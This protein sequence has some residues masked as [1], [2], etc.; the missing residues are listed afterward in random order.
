MKRMRLGRDD[1]CVSCGMALK[2]G[3]T[4]GWESMT[5]T[6]TCL[7]CLD[8]T[9]AYAL[10]AES[11]QVPPRLDPIDRGVAG[12][13]VSREAERR[14]NRHRRSQEESVATGG[15][16]L[17]ADVAF[18][19]T[20]L[21]TTVADTAA[22]ATGAGAAYLDSGQCLA[23]NKVAC[24]GAGLGIAG[25]ISAAPAVVGD[26]IGVQVDT[27]PFAAIKGTSAFGLISGLG[28]T[29]FDPFGAA[30]ADAATSGCH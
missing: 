18:E 7:S 16:G 29:I 28:A 4:A 15:V 21:T 12:A 6:V 5:K 9:P 19:G 14:A 17:A 23:G 22:L 13:S 8:Q 2:A 25:A 20:L 30:A 3:M 24:I 26:L 27:L 10:S 1:T 11:P